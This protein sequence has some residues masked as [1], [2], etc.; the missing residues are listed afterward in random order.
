MTIVTS[1]AAW[2]PVISRGPSR[3]HFFRRSRQA[4]RSL[5]LR[6][7]MLNYGTAFWG[8]APEDGTKRL[9][10]AAA[11][12]CG[13][14]FQPGAQL[15]GMEQVKL[16]RTCDASDIGV[17]KVVATRRALREWVG[18]GA[19]LQC[20]LRADRVQ[21]LEWGGPAPTVSKLLATVFAKNRIVERG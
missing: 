20:L 8:L 1:S 4:E 11:P 9:G 16:Q 15:L 10:L 3:L 6:C 21:A 13:S 12:V 18:Q 5:A 2:P 14:A 19:L 17:G 7:Y